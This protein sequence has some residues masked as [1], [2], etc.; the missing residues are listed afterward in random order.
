MASIVDERGFNQGFRLTY[1]QQ[2]RLQRRA[3]AIVEA[4]QLPVSADARANIHI[5][6]LGCGTGE[7]A[8]QLAIQTGA[9]VTGVDISP[10]FIAE[11]RARHQLD[12][13]DFTVADLTQPPPDS[14]RGKHQYI[15]GNGILHHL[16]YHLDSVLPALAR[17]LAPGGRLIFW[18]PN[19]FNPY[20]YFIF[21]Y[22]R[23]RRWARLE[24]EEMAF[25]AGFIAEKLKTAGFTDIRAD[26]RDFLLPNI[27]T[28]L[29]KPTIAIGQVA[30]RIPGL[31]QLAQSVFLCATRPGAQ[32]EQGSH[33]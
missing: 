3:T 12:R 13:L 5:L 9:Q 16:Y 10:K 4:M 7:L 27:P 28:P 32:A 15:V 24:P 1:A 33:S 18:E 20:I 11:A 8:L 6:E 23:L 30:E 29:V 19:L 14:Q 21:T 22:P 25:T 17:W 31:R 26:T 2:L